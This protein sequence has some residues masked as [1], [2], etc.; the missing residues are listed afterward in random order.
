MGIWNGL[1]RSDA[2][3]EIAQAHA[4]RPAP[5]GGAVTSGSNA[6]ELPLGEKILQVHERHRFLVTHLDEFKCFLGG[7]GAN[8]R[9]RATQQRRLGL[10]VVSSLD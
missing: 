8:S 1:R 4:Y 2:A 5:Q 10:K 7:L 9:L 3:F 6:V